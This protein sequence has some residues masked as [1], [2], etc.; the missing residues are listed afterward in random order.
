MP[1]P[2][3]MASFPAE[4]F[5]NRSFCAERRAAL[6]AGA[7][8]APEL[9][10]GTMGPM[11]DWLVICDGDVPGLLGL[12]TAADR[13]GGSVR[14]YV[15]PE[16]GGS[17]CRAEAASKAGTLYGADPLEIAVLS[18]HAV[19]ED[20]RLSGLLLAVAGAAR[21]LGL[22]VLWPVTAPGGTDALARIGE[23]LNRAVLISRLASL[24]GQ[25]VEIATP[26]ADY[27]DEHLADLVL[28]MDLPIWTCWWFD[29]HAVEAAMRP[30]AL[31]LREHWTGLLHNAGWRGPLPD[32][33]GAGS[34]ALKS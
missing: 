27:T 24:G 31:T 7:L 10:S 22:N 8:D 17:T 32:P 11:P 16:P 6:G 9:S 29:P 28:D 23:H 15:P 12:A 20:L 4:L 26:F 30:R 1:Q 2:V 33:R 13:F 14:Y 5:K 34:S 21:E 19:A 18:D 3:K 25:A